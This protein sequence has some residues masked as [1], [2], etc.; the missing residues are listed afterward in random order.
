MT[1]KRDRAR[2]SLA[3]RL[4]GGS[5]AAAVVAVFVLAGLTLWRTKHTVGQLAKDRQQATAVAVA[6]TMELAYG[7]RGGWDAVD[8]HPAMMLAVQAGASLV[9]LDADGREL[10]LDT[11]MGDMTDMSKT[12]SGPMRSAPIVVDGDRVGTVQVTFVSGELAEA[13][14]HVRDALRGTVVIGALVAA[15]A[16]ALVAAPTALRIVRPLQRVTEAARRL[17][18]GYASARAGEHRSPGEIGVLNRTFDAM[19]ERL[20]ANDVARRNLAA[21]MA[22]ELRT[23]VTLLQGSCE[24]VLDGLA[25]P[26]MEHFVHMHDDVLRLKRLVDDLG[27]LAEA[28]ALRAGPNVAVTQCD[29]AQITATAIESLVPVAEA[30]HQRL[31]PHLSPVTIDGDPTRLAQIVTNLVTNA[32]KFTQEGGAID[33]TVGPNW[34]NGTISLTVSDNG[35][36]IDPRDRPYVFERFYRGESTRPVAGS[37]IGLAVVDQLVRA[38]GGTVALEEP[39]DGT[40]IRVDFPPSAATSRGMS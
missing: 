35:P 17:G 26:S 31:N 22:H 21:D 8:P 23:P 34:L 13:E 20:E 29:L 18:D 10:S 1:A 16:A 14:A 9:I 25:A 12:A 11:P 24:S 32:I 5:V 27:A 3:V 6:D 19:A 2:V 39:A 37:G 33:V 40:A 36:G 38:H 30:K 15:L 28:D 7:Q 4:I